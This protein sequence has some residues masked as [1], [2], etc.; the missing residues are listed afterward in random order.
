MSSSL[1]KIWIIS[2]YHPYLLVLNTPQF[3]HYLL[4]KAWQ[5]ENDYVLENDYATNPY[6]LYYLLY[7]L[8]LC[9]HNPSVWNHVI[10]SFTPFLLKYLLIF[11]ADP[12]WYIIP[13]IML[14]DCEFPTKFV[15]LWELT[16]NNP[17][18]KTF[19]SVFSFGSAKP[20]CHLWVSN[21]Y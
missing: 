6:F 5:L 8:L 13:S 3:I 19:T 17:E 12:R 2:S 16:Y 1:K 4:V 15:A 9:I 14:K 7:Y 18:A 20:S 10:S 21:F 11:T